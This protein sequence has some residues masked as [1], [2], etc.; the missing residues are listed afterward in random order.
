MK[1]LVVL[2]ALALVGCGRSSVVED[3]DHP[4]SV[5]RIDD[6]G[7]ILSDGRRVEWGFHA[8]NAARLRA[9]EAAVAQ[10]IEISDDGR[11]VGL[12]RIHHWCG[13]D[14][15]GWHWARVDVRELL[16]FLVHATKASPRAAVDLAWS[17]R[18]FGRHGWN[19]SQ[20]DQFERWSGRDPGRIYRWS[21]SARWR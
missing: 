18:Q 11:A 14:P 3:L 9:V 17:D 10:G 8:P 16:E 12:V 7:L 6:R 5:S 19:V 2:S 15:V 21:D 1:L 13:N 20:W 4:T